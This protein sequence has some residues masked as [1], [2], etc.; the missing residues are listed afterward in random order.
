MSK[1]AAFARTMVGI[2]QAEPLAYKR[3]GPYWW[4][5]KALLKSEGYDRAQLSI[6]GDYEDTDVAAQVPE[7]TLH[8]ILKQAVDEYNQTVYTGIMAS[9]GPGGETYIVRDEDSPVG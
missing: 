4:P 3:F 9:A 7:K 5:V 2:M 1:Y 8:A 6:L